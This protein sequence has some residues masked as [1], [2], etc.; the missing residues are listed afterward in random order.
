MGRAKVP[1]KKIENTTTLKVTFSKRRKGLIKKAYELSVLCDIEVALIMFSPCGMLSHFSGHRR[2]ED[3]LKRYLR[4]SDQEKTPAD[5]DNKKRDGTHNV[6]IPN[7]ENL[8][9]LLEKLKVDEDMVRQASSSNNQ[10]SST[11]NLA[12]ISKDS[13][14]KDI[15]QE[16][17]KSKARL[18]ELNETTR[19][20]FGDLHKLHH[21]H[22]ELEEREMRL[23]E[24]LFRVRER[25]MLPQHKL[26]QTT[27]GLVQMQSQKEG[28]SSLMQ[29]ESPFIQ[30]T[31]ASKEKILM[32]PP[33]ERILDMKEEVVMEGNYNEAPKYQNQTSVFNDKAVQKINN[34]MGPP[35]IAFGSYQDNPWKQPW[36]YTNTTWTQPL[37]TTE[38]F[39]LF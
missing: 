1:I 19:F 21:T 2:I 5:K 17:M 15:N 25:K 18:E 11:P 36:K 6:V 38:Q 10:A 22:Q 7:K 39:P 20:L 13:A 29:Q 23:M 12:E 34:P 16:L 14:T 3:V 31:K 24:V 37:A 9:L 26:L 32:Q 35:N 30:H 8:I 27:Q 4:L 28:T 33:F